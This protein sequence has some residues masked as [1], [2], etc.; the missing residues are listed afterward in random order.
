MDPDLPFFYHTSTRTRFY[1]GIL[2]GFDEKPSKKSRQKPIPKYELLGT[3]DRI[4]MA[5]RGA[6][7][8]R[9]QFHNVR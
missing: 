8:V 7:S 6:A 5:I 1:E 2:P 4:T 3:N 9:T